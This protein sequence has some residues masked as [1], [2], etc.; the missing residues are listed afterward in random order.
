MFCVIQGAHIPVSRV[1]S[2]S[3]LSH[4]GHWGVGPVTRDETPGNGNIPGCSMS[5][6][7]PASPCP[8]YHWSAVGLTWDP[9]MWAHPVQTGHLEWDHSMVFHVIPGASVTHQMR[10]P[11]VN[12]G[13]TTT[14]RDSEGRGGTG[15]DCLS[16]NPKR[17]RMGSLL[18]LDCTLYI[19]EYMRAVRGYS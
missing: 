10:Q 4:M 19:L 18:V 5:F 8:M 2:V 16:V 13:Q 9:G 12:L 7:G 6:Q 11:K 17:A 14:L 1:P 15:L 3:H